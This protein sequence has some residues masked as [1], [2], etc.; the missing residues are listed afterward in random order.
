[1]TDA[2][3][4]DSISWI[5]LAIS[6]LLFGLLLFKHAS[7][8]LMWQEEAATAMFGV[9]VL[10]HGHPKVYGE[11]AAVYPADLDTEAGIGEG[12]A[13]RGGPWGPYYVAALAELFARGAEDPWSRTGRLR[14]FFAVLGCAGIGLLLLAV[15]PLMGSAAHRRMGAAGLL[16]LLAGAVSFALHL[17]EV[18][19]LAPVLVLLSATWFVVLRLQRARIEGRSPAGLVRHILQLT[20]LLF[21]L[22]ATSTLTSLAL[23]VTL[24]VYGVGRR[25]VRGRGGM[26][27]DLLP[28]LLAVVLLQPVVAAIGPQGLRWDLLGFE[29]EAQAAYGA[30]VWSYLLHLF[31]YEWLA[32]VLLARVALAVLRRVPGAVA[33]QGQAARLAAADLLSLFVAVYLLV[34][35]GLPVFLERHA[36]VLSPILCVILVLDSRS[37]LAWL[38]CQAGGRKRAGLV[39]ASVLCVSV[40]ASTA[41]HLPELGGR[42]HEVMNRYRGPLDHVVAYVRDAYDDPA[43]LVVATNNEG[44]ALRYYLGCIVIVDTFPTRLAQDFMYQPDLILPRP[45]GR[46]QR[47][48]GQLA[49]RGRYDQED[50]PVRNLLANNVPTLS[51]QDATGSVHRFETADL[52]EGA[53]GMPLL[54]WVRPGAG[55]AGK[56]GELPE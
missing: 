11:L 34:L 19:P 31:R 12:G 43:D 51:P 47:Q 22:G 35:A 15:S 44:S 24:L 2:R 21:L 1:M 39:C 49:V 42:F 38:A 17:R 4:L 25:L 14:G 41:L 13:Y 55:E 6:L 54:E 50:L 29:Q 10:E 37:L 36:V 20:P 48:L 5:L 3:Q 45:S 56:P 46:S 53:A 23:V 8:P 40:L 16:L 52:P 9:H 27:V 18:G 33:A 32:P 7:Y 28:L 26:A 30:S